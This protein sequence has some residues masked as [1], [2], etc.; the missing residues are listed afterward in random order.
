MGNVVLKFEPRKNLAEFCKAKQVMIR[1]R[2]VGGRRSSAN[3]AI[4]SE[5]LATLAALRAG[6]GLSN[7]AIS[8]DL[9][10][11]D[12]PYNVGGPTVYRTGVLRTPGPTSGHRTSSSLP[13]LVLSSLSAVC[14][15]RCI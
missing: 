13:I 14:I 3:I 6:F 15:R 2:C 10:Y 1:L 7:R 12:P 11:I 8:V 9:I 4:L 5:N